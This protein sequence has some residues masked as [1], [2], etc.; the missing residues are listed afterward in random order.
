M[1]VSILRKIS[2]AIGSLVVPSAAFAAMDMDSR[3]TQLE[4]Q[5]Q[6]VR[7]ETAMGTCGAKRASARP[8]VEGYGWSFTFDALYWRTKVGGTEFAYT[9][10]SPK[11]QFPMEGRAKDIDFKWNWGIRVGLGRNFAHDGWD[12][13]G[14]YTW[15]DAGGSGSA[16]VDSSG[17]VIPLKGSPTIV[18][19]ES[20]ATQNQFLYCTSAK[21]EYGFDYSALDLELGHAYFVSRKL[22]FRPHWGLKAA[23][24]DQEQITRYTGGAIDTEEPENLG[25]EGNTVHV[26]DNCDFKGL[27]PRVGFDSRWHLGNGFSIFGDIAGALVFGYFDIEHKEHYS[28]L[29]D[30]RVKLGANRHAFSPTA[31]V[32]LGLRYDNYIHNSTQHIGVGL[33]FEAQYWW[34]QNQMLTIGDTK[35]I[36]YDRYSEDISMHGLTLDIQWDF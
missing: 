7:T 22:S 4:N 35:P 28:Q 13:K 12:L 5:M 6:Q 10:Q 11:N 16:K 8:E 25:L 30:N 32:Q 19:D 21:S 34:R 15:F 9:N 29:V 24:I 36:K 26:K 3:I 2:I 31:H 27:G 18:E 23:W 17:A 20:A 14:R 1:K 33:G